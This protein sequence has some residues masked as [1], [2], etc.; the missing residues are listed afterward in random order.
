M[1]KANRRRNLPVVISFKAASCAIMHNFRCWANCARIGAPYAKS[2]SLSPPCQIWPECRLVG[3]EI[4]IT[5]RAIYAKLYFIQNRAARKTINSGQSAVNAARP[6][7]PTI[8]KQAAGSLPL[9]LE[10][11]VAPRTAARPNLI[12]PFT[13]R[14]I[15]KSSRSTK[16]C[17][18]RARRG[19]PN[20]H[21]HP[22][23]PRRKESSA[24]T[25]PS[26]ARR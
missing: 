16:N 23:P 1:S 22:E 19:I 10:T 4:P 24:S 20:L 21:G 13:A 11:S 18:P 8:R 7:L 14:I 6:S 17:D 26:R 15:L 9:R 12:T 3:G 2:K 5:Q 25:D